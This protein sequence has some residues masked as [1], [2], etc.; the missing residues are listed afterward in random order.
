MVILVQWCQISAAEGGHDALYCFMARFTR[1]S[2]CLCAIHTVVRPLGL[3]GIG[4]I[5]QVGFELAEQ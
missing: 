3:V 1:S 5:G 4:G 2:G